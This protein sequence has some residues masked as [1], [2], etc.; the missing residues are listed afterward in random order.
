M[1]GFGS[2]FP[3]AVHNGIMVAAG[4]GVYR[5]IKRCFRKVSH[6]KVIPDIDVC[7]MLYKEYNILNI[8]NV[9]GT[10]ERSLAIVID[11]IDIGSKIKEK[12][13]HFGFAIL[14]G[15]MKRGIPCLIF[16]VEIAAMC[17]EQASLR[18]HPILGCN[19]QWRDQTMRIVITA[20]VWIGASVEQSLNELVGYPWIFHAK[21]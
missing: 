1:A 13:N 4:E 19:H 2:G 14:G 8:L 17:Q 15:I 5:Y 9:T 21:H 10:M 20:L 6:D 7:P 3:Q 16:L 18:K 12:A 11:G